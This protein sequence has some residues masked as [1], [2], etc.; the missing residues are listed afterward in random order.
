M[1]IKF[2]K[3]W[4]GGE[5]LGEYFLSTYFLSEH[6]LNKLCDG[7]VYLSF[8][9]GKKRSMVSGVLTGRIEEQYS[10]SGCYAGYTI[11]FYFRPSNIEKFTRLTK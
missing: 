6:V 7:K 9:S 3:E 4:V 11:D 1:V 8:K 10:G 5:Y 2:K